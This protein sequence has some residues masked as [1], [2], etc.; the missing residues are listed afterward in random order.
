MSSEGHDLIVCLGGCQNYAPFLGPLN[1]PY[2]TEEPKRDHNFDNHPMY[3]A[4]NEKPMAHMPCA[5]VLLTA[6]PLGAVEPNTLNALNVK[7]NMVPS[8]TPKVTSF[9]AG[10]HPKPTS[11]TPTGMTRP[12][13]W[14]GLWVSEN[15]N[16]SMSLHSTYKDPRVRTLEPHRAILISGLGVRISNPYVFMAYWALTML[17]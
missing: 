4:K 9:C 6:W 8:C 5:R 11:T 7:L 13:A 17:V 15:P 1:M 16:T 10:N 12:P 14:R 3:A 2:Y